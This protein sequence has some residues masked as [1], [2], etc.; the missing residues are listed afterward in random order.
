MDLGEVLKLT[1]DIADTYLIDKPYI[2]GGLPR[3]VYLKKEE[4]K[5]T[6]VD[7]TTNSSEVLRLGILLAEELNETFELSDNGHVTVFTDKFDL[8][9]S[10]HFVS[11]A[12]VKPRY[13]ALVHGC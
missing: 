8:D 13:T 5:T 11:E 7:I 4:I 10:S 9:F 12:V 1:A 6:D 2:V 3:D